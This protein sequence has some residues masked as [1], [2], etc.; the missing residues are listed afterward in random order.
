MFPRRAGIVLTALALLLSLG[1]MTPS[2]AIQEFTIGC[3]LP[4][5]GPFAKTGQLMRDAYTLWAEEINA[6]GGISGTYPVRFIF[7]DDRSNPKTSARMVEV[8]I[9]QEKVDLLL[10]SHGSA[11]VMAASA[12]AE[13]HKYPYLC[14]GTASDKLYDRGFKY[15]FGTLGKATE[16]VR[17]CMDMFSTLN[18]KPKSVAIVGSNTPC[19]TLA[20]QGFQRYAKKYGFKV[21][22]YE[23]FPVML[24]DYNT[25]LMKAKAKRP[26]LLLVGSRLETAIRVMKAMQEI[27]F[28]PKAVAFSQGPT[29]PEFAREL[30]AKADYVF[31]ASEWTPNLP[32]TGPVFGSAR[33]FQVTYQKRFFRAP[34]YLE[35]ASVAAAVVLQ[36]AVESLRL[37]PGMS[38]ADRVRL[39]EKLHQMDLMT[40]YG[41]VRFGPDGANRAHPPVAVQLQN[42]QLINVFPAKW[43][44][45]RPQYPMPAW[46]DRR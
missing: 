10:G 11:P 38:Q 22:H 28:N 31:A 14:G 46:K 3:A 43:A 1:G 17:A 5:S 19:A 45:K 7:Y 36:K 12:V 2:L 20:C 4:L 18:P 35:A 44:E 15:I 16:Q 39:M 27:D 6:K 9:T 34:D 42:L 24:K 8:L 30:K 32:Y 33:E 21:V 23:L 40:F 26:D 41:P 25:I 37:K 13:R 29:W